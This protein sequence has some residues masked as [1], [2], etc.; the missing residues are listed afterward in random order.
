MLAFILLI[1]VIALFFGAA[2]GAGENRCWKEAGESVILDNFKLY[3]LGMAVLFGTFNAFAVCLIF[4]LPFEARGFA[5]F[6]NQEAFVAWLWLMLWDTLILDV[7]WWVIRHQDITHLG[8]IMFG[9][10]HRNFGERLKL[11]LQVC[12]AIQHAHQKGVIHRDI[13]PSNVIVEPITTMTSGRSQRAILMDFGIAKF[14]SEQTMLS[15][16]GDVLGTVDYISPEQIHGNV[17]LDSRTDQYS[18]AVMTYQMLTG[19]KLFERNNTWAMIR[20]HPDEMPP[21]PRLHISLSDGAA[22]AILKAL[23]KKPEERFASIGEFVA[24]LGKN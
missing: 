17:E 4:G 22:E 14:S 21:D 5:A 15:A 3:H 12:H 18:F 10:I 23:S 8:K 7:V 6:W 1:A 2:W 13:K 9:K 11:F 20:A 24:E 19:K 16:S